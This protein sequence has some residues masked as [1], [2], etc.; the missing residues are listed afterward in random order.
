MPS[1]LVGIGGEDGLDAPDLV[2][3]TEE[4]RRE[5]RRLTGGRESA[6]AAKG[7]E[8]QDLSVELAARYLRLDFFDCGAL[9]R[10]GRYESG[11]WKQVG[12]LLATLN[13][14]RR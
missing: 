10:L 6:S 5:E 11:L 1:T 9:E 13:W 4:T 12:Q 3:P 2:A 8:S 14:L 7:N